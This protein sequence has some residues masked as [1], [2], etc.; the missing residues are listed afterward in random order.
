[1]VRRNWRGCQ[2]WL[3]VVMFLWSVSW[4]LAVAAGSSSAP[5]L[6]SCWLTFAA[7]DANVSLLEYRSIAFQCP[8]GCLD[9]SMQSSKTRYS[10]DAVEGSYPYSP[11]SSVCLSAV[12]CGL[13][14]ATV[15]GSV[16]VS[17]FYRHDWSNGETQTIFPF[18]SSHGSTSNGISS[19]DVPSTSYTV[20]S[21]G[22]IYSF[23]VRGRGEIVM[24]R[25]SA[26]FP[27]RSGH[28]HVSLPHVS[29][30]T[31]KLPPLP[32]FHTWA[33]VIGGYNG[34]HYLNDVW[35][36]EPSVWST[37]GS[38]VSWRQ[39][40]AAPFSPRSD[41]QWALIADT[42]HSSSQLI[43]NLH[44]VGGQT[45]HMCGLTELGLCSDE[46]W[47]LAL[48]I[49]ITKGPINYQLQ[50]V[51]WTTTLPVTHLPFPSR[52]G[53]SLLWFTRTPT[54]VVIAGQLSYNDTTCR[55]APISVN[56]VWLSDG[57]DAPLLLGWRQASNASF[58]PRRSQ[59]R[60]DVL[61]IM[62]PMVLRW[63]APDRELYPL[64]GGLRVMELGGDNNFTQLAAVDVYADVWVCSRG[65]SPI[66][67]FQCGWQVGAAGTVP[68]TSLP[69]PIAFAPA[70]SVRSVWAPA[71]Q[72]FGGFTAKAAV[73]AWLSAAP[74]NIGAARAGPFNWTYIVRPV[75]D[76]NLTV[77]E[78]E[79]QRSGLPMVY[80]LTDE[81]SDPNSSYY[82]GT[83]F[84]SS[85]S[86]WILPPL[87]PAVTDD[88]L[89]PSLST[90]HP[91]RWSL[92]VDPSHS[93]VY[94]P[95]PLSSSQTQRPHFQFELRRLAA[96]YDE[97]SN[98]VLDQSSILQ[99]TVGLKV[100][101]GGRSASSPSSDW[102]AMTEVRCLPPDDPSFLTLLGGLR[103]WSTTQQQQKQLSLM[104]SVRDA[105]FAQSERLSVGCLPQYHFEPLLERV[106]E[107]VFVCGPN[108]IWL[109]TDLQT[110]RVCVPNPPQ[111]CTAPL[112][113]VG[114][115]YCQPGRPYVARL[116]ANGATS[117]DSVTLIDL[118]VA[119]DNTLHIQG[120]NFTLPLSVTVGG[121]KCDSPQLTG[122][123]RFVCYN[124]TCGETDTR[125]QTQVCDWFSDS[126]SCTLPAVLG[127]NLPVLVVSGPSALQA[128]VEVA[129][130]TGGRV[131]RVS[132]TS[133]VITYMS[134]YH[135]D[136]YDDRLC[137][138]TGTDELRLWNCPVLEP[139]NLSV[140][141]T[142]PSVH[143]LALNVTLGAS[144]TGL[145]CVLQDPNQLSRPI[146]NVRCL[147]CVVTPF[148][149]T[150][151]VRVQPSVLPL[152]QSRTDA[153]LTSALCPEGYSA[154]FTA[155]LSG[156]VTTM[157]NECAAG[158]STR[159]VKGSPDCLPCGVGHFAPSPAT[160]ECQPC[161]P[162][163]YTNMTE[164][165][166]C[167]L[168]PVNQYQPYEGQAH[169][170]GCDTGSYVVYSNESSRATGNCTRCPDGA[171]CYPDA[172]G[173]RAGRFLVIDQGAAAIESLPC[174]E[175]ACKSGD[176]ESCDA[177]EAQILLRSSLPVLNCC[178]TGRR[179]AYT[180]DWQADSA[181]ADTEGV[182]VLCAWCKPG[183]TQM[184][185]VCIP[186]PSTQWGRVVSI[187]L[188][189]LLL[190]YVVH[191][192]PHDW[193]GVA[194]MSILAYFLQQSDL[195]LSYSLLR[196][197]NMDPLGAA[198]RSVEGGDGSSDE[199]ANADWCVV[200]MNTDGERLVASLLSAP[201][202]F[203]LLAVVGLVH[204]LARQALSQL[205]V[206]TEPAELAVRSNRWWLTA[207]YSIVFLAPLPSQPSRFI[208]VLPGDETPLAALSQPLTSQ[209]NEAEKDSE[210]DEIQEAMRASGPLLAT[211]W[212][213]TLLRGT[214][215]MLVQWGYSA[216]AAA[217][218]SWLLYQRSFVR[219]LQLSYTVVA[220]LSFRFFHTI[221]V[222]QYGWRLVAYPALNPAST[223]Y[224]LLTPIMTLCL[225]LV[226]IAPL[227]L[228]IFLFRQHR[229]GAI[230]ELKAMT[231]SA[232]SVAAA[233]S[234]RSALVLQ[235]CCMFR[236]GCWWMAAFVPTRRLLVVAVL[237]VATESRLWVWLTLTNNVLLAIH[238]QVQPYERE[239]D[240]LL[241]TLTL[242]ALCL[243]TTLLCMWTPSTQP[244]LFA[245]L[246][247]GPV[248][249]LVAVKV[250][251]ALQRG[252]D[253]WRQRA[254]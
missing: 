171:T 202:A 29:T 116:S 233:A 132:S 232:A 229:R 240:N 166:T 77:T 189:S 96:G 18:N 48:T 35:L 60:E 65:I 21:N 214:R 170:I 98:G 27:P 23:T 121:Q 70:A 126:L 7:L 15:G 254:E 46:V 20:P 211:S 207:I 144:Q 69:I 88:I 195:F 108:G 215:S 133:P 122:A 246:V 24:Q 241:E 42:Q 251:S 196:T 227:L 177:S 31:A 201:T 11:A 136:P 75:P 49:A 6:S 71:G 206:P 237:V 222:G 172:I 52:C 125:T 203:L 175:L 43:V 97:W 188:L 53:P 248:L 63:Y 252:R 82:T 167:E 129:G 14:D 94:L 30:F 213:R 9:H 150:H 57:I 44:V 181:L 194:T 113:D 12:H 73:S 204:W 110:I 62:A 54:V 91:Q 198:G 17:R 173:A 1:M 56:E 118:P 244:A 148:L 200:P 149:G 225:A 156:L 61:A 163:R 165:V 111:N 107:A 219:L 250:T 217:Q 140:C 180:K 105:S 157:C 205:R 186:C 185:G 216:A 47:T 145:P 238:L 191:R 147:R 143:T 249:V 112:L 37:T 210:K 234:Q 92:A 39:L 22:S 242:F 239:R 138:F 119:P 137:N 154:N 153:S 36:A 41:M 197:F 162:G 50:N 228:A 247:L 34:S 3:L 33:F 245:A 192:F 127:L 28:L 158:S 26:P 178:G 81:L 103:W 93:S 45:A 142:F 89:L 235:L 120:S 152:L 101:S 199:Q 223:T 83:E 164:A 176:L 131:A 100:V 155:A 218:P 184:N 76:D 78:I 90:L 146:S 25:R 212:M 224:H 5:S 38:D 84:V 40:P 8:P 141:L 99:F 208:A 109:D 19:S 190:V 123:Q 86:P 10:S 168:C 183:H 135:D 236:S 114:R 159:G 128:D 66:P 169:C 59:Q 187:A 209:M 4:R 161:R 134:A 151:A 72:R 160:G 80:R 79:K 58:S 67:Q 13:L 87:S 55:S 226:L 95:M 220:L 16:F 179:P 117:V 130:V 221:P 2:S 124:L 115:R 51:S 104:S 102:I 231:P 230:A 64:A 243:Q 85:H 139:Y 174:S 68:S 253:A 193:S 32:Y 182:N 74:T 106:D